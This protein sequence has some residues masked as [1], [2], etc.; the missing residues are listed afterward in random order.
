MGAIGFV[1]THF[2]NR[3]VV[4]PE[5]AEIF[6]RRR[7]RLLEEGQAELV[8]LPHTGG[9]DIL[10]IDETVPCDISPIAVADGEDPEDARRRWGLCRRKRVAGTAGSDAESRRST[11]EA[12]GVSG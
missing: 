8:P 11:G 6:M 12:T 7:Q 10:W 4:A 9:V 2:G 3:Y 5:M 1:V